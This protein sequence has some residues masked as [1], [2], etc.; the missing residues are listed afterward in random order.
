MD[1][2]NKLYKV[3]IANCT[4]DQA[5]LLTK[6]INVD[7]DNKNVSWYEPQDKEIC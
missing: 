6:D 7:E 5:H 2:K 3:I 4:I 1:E